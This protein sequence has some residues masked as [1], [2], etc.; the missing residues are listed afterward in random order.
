[1]EIINETNSIQIIHLKNKTVWRYYD[2]ERDRFK[3]FFVTPANDDYKVLMQTKN[4]IIVG[5]NKTSNLNIFIWRYDVLQGLEE[6]FYFLQIFLHKVD[7]E[8]CLYKISCRNPEICQCLLIWEDEIY[9]VKSLRKVDSVG[10]WEAVLIDD[11]VLEISEKREY[12][13]NGTFVLTDFDVCL[14]V[15]VNYESSKNMIKT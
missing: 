4:F 11:N 14:G 6:D 1:M 2:F 8:K 13:E 10:N 15:K 12:L 7:S 3:R 5:K 9:I